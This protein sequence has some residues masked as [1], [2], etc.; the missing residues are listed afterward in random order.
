MGVEL[1]ENLYAQTMT[2]IITPEL[3]KKLKTNISPQLVI[4][5][6]NIYDLKFKN[7]CSEILAVNDKLESTLES[8]NCFKNSSESDVQ[9]KVQEIYQHIDSDKADYD[10]NATKIDVLDPENISINQS[11]C[12]AVS[13]MDLSVLGKF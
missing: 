12:Q 7:L 4:K 6:T 5:L 13:L 2:N 8:T 1:T 9:T 11:V 10:L 3:I